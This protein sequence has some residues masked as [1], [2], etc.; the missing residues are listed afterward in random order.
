M[1]ENANIPQNR[2][3]IYKDNYSLCPI[4]LDEIN[5]N[6]N[7]RAKH[8]FK[9]MKPNEFALIKAEVEVLNCLICKKD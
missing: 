8:F 6:K 5:E 9:N 3:W 2:I 4:R 7:R 1:T